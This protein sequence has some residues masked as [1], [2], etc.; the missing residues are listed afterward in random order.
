ML[1]ELVVGAAALCQYAAAVQALRVLRLTGR[2]PA[3]LLIAAVAVVMAARRS[4]V[5]WRVLA[6]DGGHAVDPTYEV[7]ALVVSLMMALGIGR[8]GPYFIAI[9]EGLVE[10]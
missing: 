5:L 6:G 1:V 9:R 3:W 4:I 8:I 7:L 2:E 10:P